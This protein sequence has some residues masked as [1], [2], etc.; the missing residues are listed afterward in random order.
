MNW[1]L[2]KNITAFMVD[3]L[4]AM[5][6]F[7]LNVVEAIPDLKKSVDALLGNGNITQAESDSMHARMAEAEAAWAAE[8]E[9]ARAEL[10]GMG[11]TG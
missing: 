3:Q 1:D 5:A 6:K 8:V 11:H 10:A 9:R 2:L 4:P 7:G